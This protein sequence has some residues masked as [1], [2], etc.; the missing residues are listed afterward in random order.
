MAEQERWSARTLL[1]TSSYCWQS[2]VLQSAVCLDL[3]SAIGDRAADSCELAERLGAD[4]RGLRMLLN[5]L[6]AMEL[7]VK[8]GDA[9][10]NA[11][12][13][14]RFLV[15]TSPEYLGSMIAHF[16]ATA[17]RW[18]QLPA[19]VLTGRPAGLQ[20]EM[21]AEE[22][23][24]F[25][26]GMHTLASAIAPRIAALLDL[27]GCTRLLDL[28]GG[29]GT[30]AI[31]FC[32]AN[33]HLQATVYDRPPSRP[34]AQRMIS[35]AGLD[36]RIDFVGGNYLEDDLPAGFDV[37]WLSHILHGE[38]PEDCVSILKKT[39]AAVRRGALVYV[40]DFILDDAG[41]RP[42]FPAIFSLN[43]LVNTPRG[44]SYCE[45][46]LVAMLS[47]AGLTEI[48]RLPFRGPNDSGIIAGRA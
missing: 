10:G 11:E 28:G 5:A 18:V 20:P 16:H 21:S 22:R 48:T 32:K 24:N 35:L 42:L 43:M 27:R 25:L 36:Q 2:F 7:L 31:S 38:G 40:H 1:E 19:A 45:H 23:E 3:F 12:A 4:P 41:D 33:P 34:F 37:A 9:Y 26:L 15:K 39:V 14:Q 6:A 30:H 29:P 13:S 46:E 44:Q 47:Q 8:D 17:V